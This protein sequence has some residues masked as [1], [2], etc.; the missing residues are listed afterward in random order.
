MTGGENVSASQEAHTGMEPCEDPG[1]EKQGKD[2]PRTAS[3][4]LFWLP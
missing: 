3:I 1:T 2:D 4:C